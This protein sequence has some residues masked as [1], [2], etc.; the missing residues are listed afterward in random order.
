MSAVQSLR[1]TCMSV[2]IF[3]GAKS[4]WTAAEPIGADDRIF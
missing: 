4:W 3:D 2:Y 1:I